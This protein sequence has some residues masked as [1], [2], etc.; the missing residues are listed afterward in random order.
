MKKDVP[1]SNRITDS[2]PAGTDRLRYALYAL[3]LTAAYMAFIYLFSNLYL[4]YDDCA[5]RSIAAG[6][7]TGVPDGH[8]MFMNYVTGAVLAFLYS[9]FAFL[10][11]FVLLFI[12]AIS[13]SMWAFL[14]KVF[15]LTDGYDRGVRIISVVLSLLLFVCL[16]HTLISRMT[17]TTIA[18][19]LATV[20][21]F[22]YAFTDSIDISDG[23]IISVMSILCFAIRYETFLMFAPYIIIHIL[24]KIYK[25]DDAWGFIKRSIPLWLVIIIGVGA[26]YIADRTA[27]NGEYSDV[28]ELNY[29]RS[30]IQD[31]GGLP[32]FS[33]HKELYD[34]LGISR[35]SHD[36]ME[37]SWGLSEDFTLENTKA[38][39]EGKGRKEVNAGIIVRGIADSIKNNLRMGYKILFC[40]IYVIS[41]IFIIARKDVPSLLLLI[42]STGF[43]LAEC[44]YILA[45]GRNLDDR[46]I[47]SF[48]LAVIIECVICLYM[49]FIRAGFK[50]AGKMSNKIGMA[51]LGTLMLVVGVETAAFCFI[52][53][54]GRNWMFAMEEY[55]MSDQD[56]LYLTSGWRSEERVWLL[57]QGRHNYIKLNGWIGE[58]PQFSKA[59]A[60]EYDS[61]LDGIAY[62]DD[63][64]FACDEE[65]MTAILDYMKQMGYNDISATK[66]EVDIYGV[67]FE[68]WRIDR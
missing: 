22:Y 51:A 53:G 18:A 64:V 34:S 3:L 68:F 21:I 4:V 36:L 63:L 45:L 44:V 8:V 54:I 16:F 32:G 23:I 65:V 2:R 14:Y 41:L 26:L 58:L 60:G 61:V 66:E 55:Y 35:E 17:Y 24:Y 57:R 12:F 27:Y 10:D 38:L 5:M 31:K 62:R 50:D 40:I 47:Y 67:E 39:A 43:A 59:L 37:I 52:E 46:L 1:Q 13:L 56:S 33:N 25:S 48:S 30:E 19:I 6:D 28:R 29:Y 7:M 11:W 15:I 20:V 49:M 9:H 42:S